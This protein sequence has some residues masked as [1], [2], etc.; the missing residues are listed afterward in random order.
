[1]KQFDSYLRKHFYDFNVSRLCSPTT[2]MVH[3]SVIK[4]LEEKITAV[5]SLL[6]GSQVPATRAELSSVIASAKAHL[7]RTLEEKIA[8]AES[9]LF[10]GCPMTTTNKAKLVSHIAGARAYL[11]RNATLGEQNAIASYDISS[12]DDDDRADGASKASTRASSGVLG[13]IAVPPTGAHFA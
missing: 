9:E 4:L 5:E 7:T 12:D 2:K 6:A 3:S 10:S 11:E 8:I 13:C 1:M